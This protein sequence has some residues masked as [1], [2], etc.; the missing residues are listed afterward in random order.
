MV[1]LIIN[2][3]GLFIRIPGIS[4]FRTPAEINIDRIPIGLVL[5]ELQNNGIKDYKI[6]NV[7]VTKQ[8]TNKKVNKNTENNIEKT[9]VSDDELLEMIKLQSGSIKNIENLLSKFL[10]SEVKISNKGFISDSKKEDE[11]VE[12]FIP[13]IN[14]NKMKLKGSSNTKNVKSNIDLKIV[15]NLKE[16]NNKKL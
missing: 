4:P 8:K 9:I 15:E 14:I 12:D 2:Q 7:N 6:E 16:M 11:P 13:E 10:N 5:S 1:K 3:P